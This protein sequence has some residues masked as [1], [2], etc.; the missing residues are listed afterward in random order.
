MRERTCRR[1]ARPAPAAAGPPP[2]QHRPASAQPQQPS[3][4]S[5]AVAEHAADAAKHLFLPAHLHLAHNVM[6]PKAV[7]VRDASLM[8]G[9]WVGLGRMRLGVPRRLRGAWARHAT[10]APRISLAAVRQ[11]A[12]W[13]APTN[14]HPPT[15]WFSTH[16][17]EGH[18]GVA[19]VRLLKSELHPAP[20]PL[21]PVAAA[22]GRGSGT[23]R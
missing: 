12:C 4:R 1:L 18:L 7:G 19:S 6:V 9:G 2:Q 13:P 23:G 3:E 11:P 15:S 22:A 14:Q 5:A 10:A 16:L 8:W 17:L 20:S 21:L